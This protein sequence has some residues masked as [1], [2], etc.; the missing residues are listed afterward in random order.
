M[1]DG[2]LGNFTGTENK[3]ERLEGAQPYYIKPF[4]IFLKHMKKLSH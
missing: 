1:I 2:T 3:I 4:P